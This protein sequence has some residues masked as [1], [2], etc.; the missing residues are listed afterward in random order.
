MGRVKDALS[1]ILD[2]FGL[3]CLAAAAF[4][5]HLAAGL[6][7]LGLAALVFSWRYGE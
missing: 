5:L 3:A 1:P 6:A 4:V 2:T 7:V